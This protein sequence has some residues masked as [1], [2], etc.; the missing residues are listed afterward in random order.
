MSS[1]KQSQS[2]KP[3]SNSMPSENIDVYAALHSGKRSSRRARNS[4]GGILVALPFKLFFVSTDNLIEVLSILDEQECGHGTNF[5][6]SCHI[7]KCQR[8][9][10]YQNIAVS[11]TEN[12]KKRQAIQHLKCLSILKT[13]AIPA[14]RATLFP[15][16]QK[17]LLLGHW[18]SCLYLNFINVHLQK[19][20]T[21]KLLAQLSE[22]WRHQSARAAPSGGEIDN[23]LQYNWLV[24]EWIQ[25]HT[26]HRS[27]L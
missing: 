24:S 18:K 16:R 20:Q 5:P 25:F 3:N 13:P 27:L 4:S 14:W 23:H 21:F 12:Y 22:D 10:I 17:H 7:L 26:L 6:L 9:K 2:K 1:L 15:N 8:T 19:E 11:S